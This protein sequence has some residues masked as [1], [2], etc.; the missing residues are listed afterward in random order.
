MVRNT[1]KVVLTLN[2]ELF[3]KLKSKAEKQN[4]D[5][6]QQYIYELIRRN[7]NHKRGAGRKIGGKFAKDIAFMKRKRIFSRRGG[8]LVD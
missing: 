3:N 6:Q 2:K 5:N 8:K 4:Y 7:V 1:L